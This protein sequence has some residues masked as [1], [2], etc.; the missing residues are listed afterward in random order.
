M[1][2]TKEWLMR[3]RKLENRIISLAR[4]RQRAYDRA[5]SS[6]ARPRDVCVIGGIMSSPDDK[7][8]SYVIVEEA[9]KEQEE[10]LNCIRAEILDVVGLIDDN[11]L[12]TVIT[13]Y[14]I[15][16]KTWNEIAIGLNY[17]F[18]HVTKELHPKAILEVEKILNNTNSNDDIMILSKAPKS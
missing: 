16:A 8:A 12:A 7:N 18:A 4:A 5:V 1:V 15:N 13:E 2:T 9:V 17:S 3:G 14:Y 6:T 11:T 10:K